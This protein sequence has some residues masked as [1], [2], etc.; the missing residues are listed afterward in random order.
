M[1]RSSCVE[2]NYYKIKF[3]FLQHLIFTCEVD[4]VC[5]FINCKQCVTQEKKHTQ[6]SRLRMCKTD[7]KDNTDLP[8]NTSSIKGKVKLLF[9][10]ERASVL[11]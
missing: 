8:V 4:R 6:E 10:T 3:P 7:S 9:M 1:C 5:V 2:K 11:L